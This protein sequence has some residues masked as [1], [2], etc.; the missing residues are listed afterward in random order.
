MPKNEVTELTEQQ[1]EKVLSGAVRSH[2][3]IKQQKELIGKQQKEIDGLRR[4]AAFSIDL[5][6]FHIEQWGMVYGLCHSIDKDQAL[7]K[8][9]GICNKVLK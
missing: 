2:T 5:V 7:T 8:I 9:K 4:D 1:K 6:Q 3:I